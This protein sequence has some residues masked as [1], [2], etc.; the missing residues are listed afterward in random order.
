MAGSDRDYVV[1]DP[2]VVL[3]RE[4]ERSAVGTDDRAF[5]VEP[6]ARDFD[7][8]VADVVDRCDLDSRPIATGPEVVAV[9]VAVGAPK[10]F[11]MRM[12]LGLA[13]QER[14]HRPGACERHTTGANERE[15]HWSVLE[16]FAH[17]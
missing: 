5:R 4:G 9:D 1:D 17:A 6:A 14:P 11:V 16:V 10:R 3:G 7:P 12:V 15:E 8:S 2:I 13:W